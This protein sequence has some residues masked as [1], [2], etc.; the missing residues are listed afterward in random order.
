MNARSFP[1]S[2]GFADKDD[3][4]ADVIRR[5]YFA[6]VGVVA[7]VLAASPHYRNGPMFDLTKLVMEPLARGRLFIAW[8]KSGEKRKELPGGIA[9][10][11]F[12]ACVSS[13][14]DRKIMRFVKRGQFPVVLEPSEWVSGD[15]HW[16]LD[17]LA[18]DLV[19]TNTLIDRY[20]QTMNGRLL[21]IHPHVVDKLGLGKLSGVGQEDH[22]KRRLN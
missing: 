19:G 14:V 9:G 22:A 2:G 18:P 11:I 20:R 5:D 3:Q 17:V 13:S 8:P 12:T 1:G 21:R 15:I 4:E 7:S 10:I 16:V 6:S